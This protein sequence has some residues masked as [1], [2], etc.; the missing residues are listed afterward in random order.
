MVAGYLS[1]HLHA[2]GQLSKVKSMLFIAVC[3][4]F[5]SQFHLS[6]FVEGFIITLSVIVLAFLL[7]LYDDVD[8]FF[9]LVLTAIV[10]P[11]FR[12]LIDY[13]ANHDFWL[14]VWRVYPD[15]AFYVAYGIFF[16][17]MYQR[18]RL[19][20][21]AHFAGAIFL[22]D[23]GA[24]IVEIL[25]RTRITGFDV[26]V[27]KYL[28]AIAF[29][30]MLVVLALILLLKQYRVFLNK[31]EHEL[32]YRKL[33]MQI[34]GFKCELYF[35]H[36]NT[37]EIE[38][39]MQKSFK[40]YRESQG[41]QYG[42]E[43]QQLALDIAKDIHEIKKDYIRVIKGLEELSPEEPNME[44][45]PLSDLLA[46]LHSDIKEHIQSNKSD[47]AVEWHVNANG[48][49]KEHFYL[50]SV[51]RNL[52]LNAVEAMDSDKSGIIR[53]EA[54]KYG[55]EYRFI[56]ADNGKGIREDNLSFIFDPGF[57]TKFDM[58]TG[59]INRGVG[60][61][62]VRDLVRETFHGTIDVQST[63]GKGTTFQV[64]IP[65]EAFGGPL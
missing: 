8:P 54:S 41:G 44:G 2:S 65:A 7:Y 53:M 55:D 49:V 30:R 25:I 9:T 17:V 20:D 35:L 50:M 19:K 42:S 46:I 26:Q 34:S 61:T 62:L 14:T 23:M 16:T 37:H 38:D 40:L 39:V 58:E 12:G 63:I 48:W 64:A 51:L 32:R 24:N 47:V 4:A 5:A 56:V 21:L 59:E 31:E 6:V 15:I 29:V 11:V 33:M 3:V 22:C 13:T 18:R 1:K 36:K 43:I 28:A 52:V 57:T 60:L 45:M 27:V 10:S